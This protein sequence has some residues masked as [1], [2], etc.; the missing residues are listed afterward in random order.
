MVPGRDGEG[1][2]GEGLPLGGLVHV[3]AVD[4]GE[5]G[6]HQ[7]RAP[8]PTLPQSYRVIII[9]DNNRAM[10]HLVVVGRLAQLY[11]LLV[12]GLAPGSVG[13]LL[14]PGG[15]LVPGVRGVGGLAGRAGAGVVEPALAHV[16]VL[17]EG[18][19]LLLVLRLV[20]PETEQIL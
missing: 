16:L 3:L 5:V 14:P 7:V 12:P 11:D 4:V 17:R 6:R 20:F 18:A 9:S 13:P 19:V 10:C 8:A 1:E 2:G 15:G